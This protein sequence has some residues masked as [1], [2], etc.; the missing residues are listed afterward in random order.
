MTQARSVP[1]IVPLR[2]IS[3]VQRNLQ[4]IFS[5]P[6]VTVT[7]VPQEN[8]T[9]R[10]FPTDLEEALGLIRSTAAKNVRFSSRTTEL[11]KSDIVLATSHTHDL[12]TACWS[13][14][15]E[16]FQGAIATWH[17]DNLTPQCQT[18]RAPLAPTSSFRRTVHSRRC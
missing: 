16:G 6:A 17:W 15:I 7:V 3:E 12:S 10:Y 14:R 13:L 1:S 2:R 18:F 5:R 9:L 11:P 4:R 8:D